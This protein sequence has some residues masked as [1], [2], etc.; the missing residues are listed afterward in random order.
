[1]ASL[2]G[3]AGIDLG[4]LKVTRY[5]VADA[6]ATITLHRPE[7]LNAWTGRMHTEYR[8]LLSRA[9]GRHGAGDRGDRRRPGI[10][11]RSR[12][13]GARGPCGPGRL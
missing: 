5:A 4:Q 10:L 11:C 12:H 2:P 9:A 8:A 13:K 6:I 3:P 7:R 1:M